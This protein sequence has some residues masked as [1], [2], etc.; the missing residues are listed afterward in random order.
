ML[1]PRSDDDYGYRSAR[2][3][4]GRSWLVSGSPWA[5][6]WW[7]P[8]FGYVPKGKAK[9]RVI[10][11]AFVRGAG[12]GRVYQPP[13]APYAPIEPADPRAPLRWL[14]L[15]P[16]PAVP[17]VAPARDATLFLED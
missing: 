17:P 15:E 5:E 7:G 4:R 16:E 8:V 11:E 1:D 3:G 9:A 6:R 12:G 14:T 2:G 13:P 10:C